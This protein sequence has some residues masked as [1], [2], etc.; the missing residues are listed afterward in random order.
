MTNKNMR[1]KMKKVFVCTL[2]AAVLMSSAAVPAFADDEAVVVAEDVENDEVEVDD[3]ETE[4]QLEETEDQD[5]AETEVTE[6]TEDTAGFDDGEGETAAVGFD[7]QSAKYTVSYTDISGKTQNNVSEVN[8]KLQDVPSNNNAGYLKVNGF[9]GKV[10]WLLEQY[11]T[12]KPSYEWTD[13]MKSN[14]WPALETGGICANGAGTATFIAWDADTL[15]TTVHK[16]T[17]P[18]ENSVK[19]AEVKVTVTSGKVEEIRLVANG[20]EIQNNALTVQGSEWVN[21]QPQ[22]RE[23]G[24]TE[25]KNVPVSSVTFPKSTQFTYEALVTN[26]EAKYRAKRPGQYTLTV[27]GFGRKYNLTVTSAYVPVQSIEPAFSG[28]IEVYPSGYEGN[29]GQHT[30]G[31]A[32]VSDTFNRSVNV[33]P[34]NASYAYNWTMTSSNPE[35]A[36]YTSDEGG[37]KGIVPNKIGEVTFTVTSNDANLKKQVSGSSTVKFVYADGVAA[38]MYKDLLKNLPVADS[39]TAGYADVVK[40]ARYI[41]DNMSKEDKASVGSD[42]QLTKYEEKLNPSKT[43]KTEQKAQ[44]TVTRPEVKASITLSSKT[45]PLKV[46]QSTSA[47]VI[48]KA[49]VKGDAIKSAVSSNRKVVSVSVKNGKLTVKGLKKGTANVTV[50]SKEGATATF[51]VTV[52][53]KAVALKKLTA[54]VNKKVTVKKGKKAALKVTKTPVTAAGNVKWSSSNKKVATVSSRGVVKGKKKGTATITAKVGKK[55]VRF[56]VTVK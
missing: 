38:D 26:T 46:K 18:T 48:K 31:L 32:L 49:S 50:T 2:S 16:D 52:Q 19:L 17:L 3:A 44:E 4:A 25:W 10:A 27:E 22:T 7:D 47:V 35:V 8:I 33:T 5:E 40:E 51:K 24:Q 39:V 15:S 12:G 21:L 36:E 28:R 45:L 34:S 14:I 20:Q 37:T 56:K 11:N 55:T 54:A 1:G 42:N 29:E 53:K 30:L 6:D 41:Y 43:D 23:E 9:T 13:D